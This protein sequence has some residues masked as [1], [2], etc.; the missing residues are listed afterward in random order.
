MAFF[1]FSLLAVETEKEDKEKSKEKVDSKS[2]ELVPDKELLL[3][4]TEFSDAQG[5]WV[6]PE[7]FNQSDITN[8]DIELKE[9]QNEDHPNN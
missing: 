7:V 6:D 3:F 2:S 9:R 1:S 4:L 5:D 8:S